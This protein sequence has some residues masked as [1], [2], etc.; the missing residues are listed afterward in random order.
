MHYIIC[1]L[2]CKNRNKALIHMNNALILSF[3]PCRTRPIVGI[4]TSFK[5]PNVSRLDLDDKNC[6]TYAW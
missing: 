2:Y 1:N 6:V 5:G 3:D 4:M